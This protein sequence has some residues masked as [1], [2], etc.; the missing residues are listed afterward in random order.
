ML[1]G[2]QI[3]LEVFPFSFSETL[4]HR[5]KT[6]HK[7]AVKKA[8]D[9]LFLSKG[10]DKIEACLADYLRFGGFPEVVK[11]QD[12]GSNALLL[13][14]YISD[15]ILRDVARRHNVRKIQMLQDLAIFLLHNVANPLNISRLAEI[16][17]SN[18][19]TVLDLIAYLE[20]VYLIF[21]GGSFSFSLEERLSSTRARKVFCI[22]NGFFSAVH[23][24]GDKADYQRVCNAVFQQ[25]RFAWQEEVFYWKNKV[26]IDFVL[27]DGLA[28][29]V[30]QSDHL[31][32]Q[33]REIFRMF[34]YLHTHNQPLGLMI[35][36]NRLQIHE[37]NQ[38]RVMVMPLW[39]FLL[40]S[41]EE[42]LTYEA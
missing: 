30:S 6:L 12:A 37:E 33:E 13:Q 34:H 41:R 14:Q 28:I 23:Q 19:N 9:T 4:Q 2:R 26:E 42:I 40:K 17:G 24:G 3:S 10:S 38:R 8:I 27:K 11:N 16:L 31:E 39:I 18:R 5:Q 36:K 7:G 29:G 22:D 21:L 35:S 20:E 1:T 32:V 15:I 25:L